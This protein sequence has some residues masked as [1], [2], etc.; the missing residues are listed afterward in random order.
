MNICSLFS[1]TLSSKIVMGL[2][3]FLQGIGSGSKYRKPWVA[4]GILG[5]AAKNLKDVSGV[6]RVHAS[7]VPLVYWMNTK[8]GLGYSITSKKVA[9]QALALTYQ[10]AGLFSKAK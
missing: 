8:A 3:L 7:R 9:D 10:L 4:G 6:T 1:Q 5:S 2:I